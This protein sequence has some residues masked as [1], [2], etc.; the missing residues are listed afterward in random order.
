MISRFQ[1][2]IKHLLVLLFG[3]ITLLATL[4]SYWYI[5]HIYAAQ[6]IEDRGESLHDAAK[7]T[8]SVLASNLKERQREVY[9]LAQS[10]LFRA[11]Q[12]TDAELPAV[13]NRAKASFTYYSW[14]GLADTSGI[15]RASTDNVLLGSNVQARPWFTSGR[16]QAY[17]GDLHQALLLAKQLAPEPYGA[18]LQLIDFSEPVRDSHGVVRGVLGAHVNWNW[19]TGVLKTMQPGNAAQSQVQILI[20][21]RDNTIIHPS[22]PGENTTLPASVQSR[23]AFSQDVWPDGVSYVSSAVP[24]Q[25]GGP[26]RS[27]G[28]RIVVRQPVEAAFHDLRSIQRLL[29]WISVI[30]GGTFLALVWWGA[31]LISRPLKALADHA[32][33]IEQGDETRPLV[34]STQALELRDLVHALQGMAT[35]LL[36]RKNALAKSNAVLEQT[37]AERTA[38]LVQSNQE[39]HRL[40][41]H[42]ALTGLF[43]RLA[44]KERLHAEFA[45]MKRAQV[46]YA[47]L[48]MDIDF[49]KKV[50]DTYGHD[51]GDKV[52]QAVAQVLQAHLRETD[53]LARFGGEEFVA[54]LPDTTLYQAGEVAEKLRAAVAAAPNATGYPL[55]LS[56]GLTL[57]SPSDDN[58]DVAMNRADG[59]LYRAK[60]SGR[61]QVA[62]TQAL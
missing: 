60:N 50:N 46:P 47:V 42:D 26:E 9:L 7:A 33:S 58:E 19:A 45:R 17:S 53:F 27:L 21:N 20:V 13:L 10:N 16:K 40:S 30:A 57:A 49:F 62:T 1:L 55:T 35:T 32:R 25:D 6:L 8:A 22:L 5:N 37:V 56:I 59:F 11:A 52:L 39:L 61:N 2:S 41:R 4:P 15:V 51:I 38:E 3:G 29:L 48:M 28:W 18:P 44:A 43:N 36:Q 24:V 23:V 14:L 12:F 31:A 34:V 54:L